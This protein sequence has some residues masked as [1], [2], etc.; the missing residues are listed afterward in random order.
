MVR[1]A[2]S[3]VRQAAA[4]DPRIRADAGRMEKILGTNREKLCERQS[5]RR[6][7]GTE[8][9]YMTPLE[10]IP[11]PAGASKQKSTA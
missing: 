3:W 8:I 10:D 7:Q 6:K 4:E 9:R 11:H 1:Q 5:T 2:L